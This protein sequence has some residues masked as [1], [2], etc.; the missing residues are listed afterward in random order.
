MRFSGRSVVITGG[1]S[2][3]G[4]VMAQ[5]FA[6]EGA[7]VLVADIRGRRPRGGCRDRVGR[8]TGLRHEVD[9]T[10]AE[11]VDSMV[12]VAERA[13]GA[14]D[15]LVNTLTRARATTSS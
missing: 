3:I 1:G 12:G 13:F 4:R 5:R 8:R 15:V 6:A 2:G 14:V 7:A 9:V 10:V 11:D